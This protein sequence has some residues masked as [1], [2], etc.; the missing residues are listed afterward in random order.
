MLPPP[1]GYLA[2]TRTIGS[3]ASTSTG[4]DALLPVIVGWNGSTM[5]PRTFPSIFRCSQTSTNRHGRSGENST[6]MEDAW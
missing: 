3:W 2:S 1:P 4:S 5:P 6:V